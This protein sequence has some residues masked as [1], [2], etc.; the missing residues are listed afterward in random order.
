[1]IPGL[2]KAEFARL[3]G[4]HRNTFVNSPKVLDATLHFEYQQRRRS[5]GPALLFWPLLRKL[6]AEKVTARQKESDAKAIEKSLALYVD[7]V[8]CSCSW[9]SVEC[10]SRSAGVRN[11]PPPQPTTPVPLHRLR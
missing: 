7:S 6:V 3:G 2:E 11:L 1:M 4:I 8:L 10:R 5:F 9:D